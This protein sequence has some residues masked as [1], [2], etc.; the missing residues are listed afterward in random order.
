MLEIRGGQQG[1][2]EQL[3]DKEIVSRVLGNKRGFNPGRGRVLAGS[4][5]SSSVRSYPAPAQQM[6]QSQ[7]NALARFVTDTQKHVMSLHE[8][9]AD[10]NIIDLPPLPKLD[11]MFMVVDEEEDAD[12]PQ[13]SK[14]TIYGVEQFTFMSFWTIYVYDVEQFTFMSS[15]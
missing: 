9:L 8:Q 7:I 12:D 14:S 11:P 15:N 5:S 4:S 3:T 13:V 10:R 6:T 2:E 1:Q